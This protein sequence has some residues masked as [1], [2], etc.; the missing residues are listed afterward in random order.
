MWYAGF[1]CTLGWPLQI[2]EAGLNKTLWKTWSIATQVV[3]V[4]KN[5]LADA[6]VIR[7]TGPIPGSERSPGGGY[8]NPPQYSCLE[9]FTGRGAWRAT[10]HGVTKS[11]TQL[12]LLSVIYN[13][14]LISAV[15]QSDSAV[16]LYTFFFQCSFSIMVYH[17]INDMNMTV[18]VEPCCLL[19][20]C[21]EPP[22]R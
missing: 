9:N 22:Q 17:R 10:V 14:V 6:G 19:N 15:Q 20:K 16:H 13:V 18:L 4:V 3:L 2:L 1:Y 21:L 11:W 8:G 7:D 12:K 5:L